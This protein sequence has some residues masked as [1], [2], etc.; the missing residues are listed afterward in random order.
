M[1]AHHDI[2]I[3]VV[4]DILRNLSEGTRSGSPSELLKPDNVSGIF[5]L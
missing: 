3:A 1:N 5:R 2:R 4:A